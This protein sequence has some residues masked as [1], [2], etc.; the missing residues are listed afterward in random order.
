MKAMQPNAQTTRGTLLLRLRDVRNAEAW[1]QFVEIYSPIVYGFCR[2]QG[3]QD[4]D[5]SDVCQEVLRAVTKAMETFE[6]DRQRGKFRNWLLTVTRSKLSNFFNS[7]QRKHEPRG[8]TSLQR[9]LDSAPTPQE[10][11][12][13]DTEYHGRLFHWAAEQVKPSIQETTWQAFWRTTIDE[14]DALKVAAELHIGIGSVYTAKSR[15]LSRLKEKIR[16][17]DEEAESL[18]GEAPK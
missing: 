4:A 13:W 8:D 1:E 18:P 7:R 16:E 6:Y 3:L 9:L 17:V 11:K 15:V 12:S 14:E 2:N 5:A 10:K